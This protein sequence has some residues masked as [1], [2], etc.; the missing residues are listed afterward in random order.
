MISLIIII[1]LVFGSFLNVCIYR[2]PRDESIVYPPSHCTKC[3][4]RLKA[5]DLIPIF[6]YLFSKGRCRYCGEK[7]SMQYPI[8]ELLNCV[9]VFFVY[10]KYNLSISFI[11]YTALTSVLIVISFIDYYHQIIPDELV[12]FCLILGIIFNYT[13]HNFQGG[14]L[15]LIIGGGLFLLISLVS[16]GNMGGGDILLIGTLG[17]MFGWKKILLISLFSFVI[18]AIIS[19]VLILL[20]IK[21]RKDY[22]PF[23][24]FIAI[25]TYIVL[26]FG[27]EMLSW[28]IQ[29]YIN[30]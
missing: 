18:G 14:F 12:V 16:K 17:F 8:V 24:P 11:I 4:S 6:S 26:L 30:F 29:N 15:G 13:Y 25:S 7:I 2:I 27:N 1:S 19:V 5:L 21:T 22:I 9:L 23:G 28:Y 10:L 3:G 20:G